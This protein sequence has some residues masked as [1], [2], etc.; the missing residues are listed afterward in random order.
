MNNCDNKGICGALNGVTT[1]A[2]TKSAHGS[3]RGFVKNRNYVENALDLDLLSRIYALQNMTCITPILALWDIA[4]AF[5][6]LALQD[7]FMVLKHLS[8]PG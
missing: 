1:V 3:Q 7:M 5:P 2:V 6:S 8:M 4:A